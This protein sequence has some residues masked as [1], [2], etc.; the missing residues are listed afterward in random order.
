MLSVTDRAR[1]QVREV[2]AGREQARDTERERIRATEAEGK[3][4]WGVGGAKRSEGGGESVRK[5][6]PETQKETD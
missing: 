6:E 5:N 2:R 4:K 1:D 3:T